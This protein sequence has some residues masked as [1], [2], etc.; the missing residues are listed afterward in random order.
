MFNTG[1]VV[2][3]S[4][5]IYGSGYPGSFIPSFSWG[6]AAGFETYR[7]AKALETIEMGMA[8][9]QKSLT[10][11]DRKIINRLFMLT[12]RYRKSV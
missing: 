2:G 7:V 12:G 11:T 1:T 10:E 3:I 4:S 5:N 8:L 6:G 9:H